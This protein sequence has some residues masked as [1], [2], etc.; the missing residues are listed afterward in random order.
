MSW[1]MNIDIIW[2]LV[3]WCISTFGVFLR[4]IGGAAGIARLVIINI[5]DS[6]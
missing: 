5:I 1:W 4:S 6:Y 2:L 3:Y